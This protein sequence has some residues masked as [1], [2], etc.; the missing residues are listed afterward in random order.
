M[1]DSIFRLWREYARSPSSYRGNVWGHIRNQMWHG[2]GIGFF[3][4]LTAALVFPPYAV[5]TLI[6]ATY[7]ILIE[8]PQWK[9][10][11]AEVWDCVE[12]TAHVL[13]CSFAA[14]GAWEAGV[15]QLMFVMS[16]ALQ[17]R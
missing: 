12:D 14:A 6:I 5:T 17:R 11:D 2:W 10:H 13:A 15:I 3:G 16:G 4:T 8:Y 7:V 9:N 1:L